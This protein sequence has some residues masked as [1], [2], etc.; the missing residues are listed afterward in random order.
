MKKILCLFLAIVMALCGTCFSA[1]ADIVTVA[2]YRDW[3]FCGRS[4]P[5]YLGL[6]IDSDTV[7]FFAECTSTPDEPE[8]LVAHI[9]GVTYPAYSTTFDFYADGSVTT[10]PYAFPSGLYKIYFVG[11][12]DVEKS[13]AYAVFTTID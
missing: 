4:S 1:S 9:I 3:D 10:Y 8:L 7:S 2:L 12:P 13:Y 5:E 6:Q 11:D